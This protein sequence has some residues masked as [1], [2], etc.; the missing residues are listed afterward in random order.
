MTLADLCFFCSQARVQSSCRLTAMT[1]TMKIHRAPPPLCRV[2]PVAPPSPPATAVSKSL[3]FA[4]QLFHLPQ[5]LSPSFTFAPKTTKVRAPKTWPRRPPAARRSRSS[6]RR[7][8]TA[9]R[10]CWE[11]EE[12]AAPMRRA[13]WTGEPCGGPL[14]DRSRERA[15]RTCSASTQRPT[16]ALCGW[17]QRTGGTARKCNPLVYVLTFVSNLTQCFSSA[18]TCTSPQTTSATGRTA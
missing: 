3:K 8:P 17:A 16:R 13:R 15:W 11:W 6:Q 5:R 12:G 2:R 18:S 9:P 14:G 7:A 10:G 4:L 1:Q